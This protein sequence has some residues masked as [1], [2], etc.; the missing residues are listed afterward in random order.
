MTNKT[1]KGQEK[2]VCKRDHSH[3][4]TRETP[5]ADHEAGNPVRENVVN[6]TCTKPG[7]YEEVVYCKHCHKELSRK[8]VTTDP[9]GHDW[10]EWGV[11]KKATEEKTGL[12][13]RVCK[14]CGEKEYRTIPKTKVKPLEVVT[15]VITSPTSYITMMGLAILGLLGIIKKRYK[16]Q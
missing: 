15:G 13:V 11:S 12:A 8:K 9:L 10:S 4:E 3:V 16:E 2:R 14:R 7:S 6:P 1:E 5:M